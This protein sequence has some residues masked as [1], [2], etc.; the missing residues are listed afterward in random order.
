MNFSDTDSHNVF[1][2]TLGK[3]KQLLWYVFCHLVLSQ[4]LFWW[5]KQKGWEENHVVSHTV[6]DEAPTGICT[7]SWFKRQVFLRH[8]KMFHVSFIYLRFCFA[9]Q[10]QGDVL[11]ISMLHFGLF[12]SWHRFQNAK[13]CMSVSQWV[14]FNPDEVLLP[15]LLVGMPSCD[16]TLHWFHWSLLH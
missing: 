3:V 2:Q 5:R 13:Y 14:R 12:W 8:L 16:W 10:Q 4:V 9:S 11:L 6:G 15:T 1:R 7:G